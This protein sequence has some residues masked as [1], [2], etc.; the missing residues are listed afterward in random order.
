[1]DGSERLVHMGDA[2]SGDFGEVLRDKRGG[3]EGKRTLLQP[4]SEPR[5][6]Q[7]FGQ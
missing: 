6:C 3:R 4:G 7:R 1:V 5:F 2:A